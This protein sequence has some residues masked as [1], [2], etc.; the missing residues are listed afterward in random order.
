MEIGVQTGSQNFGIQSL[1]CGTWNSRLEYT[2]RSVYITKYKTW[3]VEHGLHSFANQSLMLKTLN[4]QSG[5]YTWSVKLT[6][7]GATSLGG[8]LAL[9][10]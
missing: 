3:D 10:H 7:F 1:E 2:R 8:K 9:Q 5:I 4:M 6:K